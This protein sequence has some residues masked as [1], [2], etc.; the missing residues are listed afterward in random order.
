M[1]SQFGLPSRYRVDVEAHS[2]GRKE[3]GERI[4]L[5]G[6]NGDVS[7][8][9]G[10]VVGQDAVFNGLM[11]QSGIDP[12]TFRPPVPLPGLPVASRV[13]WEGAV[14][15]DVTTDMAG[16]GQIVDGLMLGGV[17]LYW[18]GATAPRTPAFGFVDSCG[19]RI[20]NADP[21]EEHHWS[22]SVRQ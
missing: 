18:Y 19:M 11:L 6:V 2:L 9:V 10:G 21:P 5:T 4:V 17:A 16:R 15:G 13:T 7:I 20:V 14:R 8:T 3:N 12:E 22:L 1:F